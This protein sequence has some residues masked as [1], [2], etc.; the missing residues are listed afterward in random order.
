MF[1]NINIVGIG[2]NGLDMST[3][4]SV[5]LIKSADFII[6]A[7]RMLEILLKMQ[8]TTPT[9]SLILSDEIV[10]EIKNSKAKNIVILMS[11]DTGFHSGTTKLIELL[12]QQNIKYNIEVTP[13]ISSIQYMASKI[14]LPWQDVFLTSAHGVDCNYI[15]TVLKY[16]QSFFLVGGK[17]TALDIVNGLYKAGFQD[18]TIYIGENLGYPDEKIS[19]FTL[20]SIIQINVS[21]L[22]VVWVVRNELF[23]DS[24]TGKL[25]DDDFIRGKVPITKSTI[26]NNIISQIGRGLENKILYDV[27]SGTGSIAIELA[28]SNPLSKIY[29]FECNP[30]AIELLKQNIYKFNAYNITLVEGKAPESF[31]KIPAPDKVFIGGSKG[32]MSP[33]FEQVLTKN[34][35]CYFVVSAIAVETFAEIISIFNIKKFTDF[36][37]LQLYV[38]TNKE[39]GNYNMLMGENPTFLISGKL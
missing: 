39:V 3:L 16:K 23:I 18:L 4:K 9:K 29:A 5:E 32:A 30:D 17:I 1:K 38:A 34:I 15:G 31:E 6:G 21:S 36:N 22:S 8:I 20:N 10:T 12:S 24:Y 25:T 7:K 37:V 14:N 33:I 2:V 11:G 13:G 35:K 19:K 28:L 26:R 27:G